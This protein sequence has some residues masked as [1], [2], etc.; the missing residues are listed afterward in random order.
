VASAAAVLVSRREPVLLVDLAG[1]DLATFL[2][3]EPGP[4]GLSQWLADPAPPIDALSRMERSV[5]ENLHLLGWR[6]T[7]EAPS[8]EHLV[9]EDLAHRLE[10]L[11]LMLMDDPRPVI[12]DLGDLGP[13]PGSP[14]MGSRWVLLEAAGRSTLVTRLCYVGVTSALEHNRPDDL[15]LVIE[16]GRALRPSD[17]QAALG[18]SDATRIRWDPAVARAADSGLLARRLPRPLLRIPIHMTSGAAVVS[19]ARADDHP[20]VT[21]LPGEVGR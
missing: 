2:G 19:S 12:V 7:G 6:G 3:V 9:V 16:P 18:V 13:S 15:A 17:V 21:P 8:V 1:G 5:A 10:V 4:V 20:T 14:G 11:S